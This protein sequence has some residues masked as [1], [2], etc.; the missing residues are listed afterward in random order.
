MKKPI[1][2]ALALC[3]LSAPLMAADLGVEAARVG[4]AASLAN[5]PSRKAVRELLGMLSDSSAP[6]RAKACQSLGAQQHDKAVKPLCELAASDP[7]ARV[8]AAAAEAL[9]LI[10]NKTAA[11][12]LSKAL[13]TDS[14]EKMRAAS[15]IAL[16]RLLDGKA[17]FAPLAAAEKDKS[18]VVRAAVA[19]ALGYEKGYAAGRLL[20]YMVL[21]DKEPEVRAT[22]AAALGMCCA[23][24]AERVYVD[25]MADDPMFF[26]D[27]NWDPMPV[28]VVE[29]KIGK[30]H[31]RGQELVLRTLLYVL[32]ADTDSRVRAGAAKGLG[33]TS[34]DAAVDPLIKAM[35][36]DS[37]AQVRAA[38]AAAL[39][40]L[41]AK[42][43]LDPLA[44]AQKDPD[45]DVRMEASYA[46][47][48]IATQAYQP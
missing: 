23:N 39:G 12:T 19:Y 41:G 15:A 34:S 7:D 30:L 27:P 37:D 26:W 9:G 35:A 29:V 32:A 10:Q 46:S 44:A 28:E 6:V 2:A 13:A 21:L 48:N 4:R 20:A 33:R 25:T 40:R 42:R 36:S 45:P 11:P 3:L 43:A 8:R 31:G 24:P 18:P 14:D 17:V 47:E 22:A 1:F 16:G 5:P 38:A